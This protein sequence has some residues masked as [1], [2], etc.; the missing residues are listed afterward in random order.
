MLEKITDMLAFAKPVRVIARPDSLLIRDHRPTWIVLLAGV[1][2]VI[3]LVGFV[4]YLLSADVGLDS[5]GMWFAG[6]ITVGLLVVAFRGSLFETYYFDKTTNSYRFVR[7]SIHKS[8]V[9]E[10]GLGQF[11]AVRV[12]EYVEKNAQG[13]SSSRYVV[14]LLQDGP[15]LG[16]A[17]DQPLR[18]DRPFLSTHAYRHADRRSR[19]FSTFRFTIQAMIDRI[20]P[21]DPIR[22][23]RCGQGVEGCGCRP[24]RMPGSAK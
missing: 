17:Y 6:A 5:M 19:S 22:C 4:S 2:F 23:R 10:G 15:T 7:R 8:D 20:T 13:H 12:H 18:D 14:S 16:G 3:L 24:R 11:R 9:I 1:G 21:R